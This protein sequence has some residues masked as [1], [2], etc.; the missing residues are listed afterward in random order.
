MT[1][2]QLSVCPPLKGHPLPQHI[3]TVGWLPDRDAT[4]LPFFSSAYPAG[5][6]CVTFPTKRL[7]AHSTCLGAPF[8]NIL[9]TRHKNKKKKQ[10]QQGDRRR[11]AICLIS[12]SFR[13]AN[14]FQWKTLS[15]SKKSA[16]WFSFGA[17]RG[18]KPVSV[19]HLLVVFTETGMCSNWLREGD[20]CQHQ[21]L[22]FKYFATLSASLYKKHDTEEKLLSRVCPWCLFFSNRNT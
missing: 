16:V 10:W 1:S 19:C 21:L 8:K 14:Q 7:D 11:T 13:S 18:G 5:W 20:Y 17:S 22:C 9:P 2:Q 6:M 4:T 12:S 15:A 3:I